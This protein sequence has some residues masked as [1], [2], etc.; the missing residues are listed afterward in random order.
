MTAGRPS[1]DR[2]KRENPHVSLIVVTYNS[3]ELLSAFFSALEQTR[4]SPREVIVVDNAST[5]GTVEWIRQ[6]HPRVTIVQNEVGVGYAG[7]CHVGARHAHGD[8]LV[9][10]NPDVFVTEG[11]LSI[12][13]DHLSSDPRAAIIAPQSYPPGKQ[14]TES[15]VPFEDISAVPGCAMMVRRHAWEALGGFDRHFFLYWEDAEFCWRAWLCGWRVLVDKQAFVYHD[16]SSSGGGGRWA[17]DQLRNGLYTHLKLMRWRRVASF[18]P[19]LFAKTLYKAVKMRRPALIAIWLSARP[20]I[21]AAMRQRQEFSEAR[22]E[23]ASTLEILMKRRDREKR[24]ERLSETVARVRRRIGTS[25]SDTGDR[26]GP[27]LPIKR[28]KS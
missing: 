25:P 1:D 6:F 28:R 20:D 18:L 27:P 15:P 7:A 23:N 24:R 21:A 26:P 19:V 2:D 8:L 14:H 22:A 11:W 12:L 4:Y 10:M 5:D 3:E 16:E 17:A 9:F 13:V